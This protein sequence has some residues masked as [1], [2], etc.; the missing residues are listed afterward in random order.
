LSLDRLSNFLR[1][2]GWQLSDEIVALLNEFGCPVGGTVKQGSERKCHPKKKIKDKRQTRWSKGKN[3]QNATQTT[4]ALI[5]EPLTQ[6]VHYPQL[7]GQS[8]LAK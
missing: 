2:G 5:L 8:L 7:N 1:K 3:G 4:S 6:H